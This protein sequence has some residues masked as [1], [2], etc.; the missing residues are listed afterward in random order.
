LLVSILFL[1]GN[2]ISLSL[3]NSI[4]SG[5]FLGLSL[6][7]RPSMSA[8]VPG[9][10]VWP[11]FLGRSNERTTLF[12]NVLIAVAV[13]LMT[14]VPWTV[15]NYVATGQLV[16]IATSGGKQ[17][18]YGNNPYSTGSTTE[19]PAYPPELMQKLVTL[20]DDAS[21]ERLLYKEGLE[22][23]RLHP[24]AALKLYLVRLANLFQLY[25]SVNTSGAVPER[26]IAR[27]MVTLGSIILFVLAFLGAVLVLVK[28]NPATVL[29]LIILS[30]C[31]GSAVFLIAMRYR[32]P[33]DPYLIL[34][35]SGA[36]AFFLR[37]P[38]AL[39]SSESEG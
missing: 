8:I 23:I 4:L 17:F 29:P 1:V 11:A 30:Y 3:R 7:A 10:L 21:R 22:F 13:S 15:H 12:R 25:P 18:W 6:L 36:L 9:I 27:T 2:G 5:F 28:R 26:P 14:V 34:L 16:F 31:L 38:S 37:W 33:M 24:K 32:L 35:G 20:P 19:I 39:G